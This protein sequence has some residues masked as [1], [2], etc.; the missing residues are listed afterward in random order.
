MGNSHGTCS[1]IDVPWELPELES[2]PASTS[3]KENPLCRLVEAENFTS[4]IRQNLV[5]RLFLAGNK[6]LL[7]KDLGP[8]TFPHCFTHDRGDIPDMSLIRQNTF[9][10]LDASL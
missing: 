6:S 3:V 4:V 10:R 8:Q 5:Y 2:Q 7:T 1:D 9:T